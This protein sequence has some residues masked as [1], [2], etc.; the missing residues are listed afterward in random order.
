MNVLYKVFGYFCRIRAVFLEFLSIKHRVLG[1]FCRLRIKNKKRSS[2][3]TSFFFEVAEREGFEPPVPL[4]TVV[5]KTTVIDHS[6]ISPLHWG[7]RGFLIAGAKVRRKN[8]TT[9]FFGNYFAKKMLLIRFL[10]REAQFSM[11]FICILSNNV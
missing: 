3:R 4:G 11:V 8:E 6:T 1:Y 10:S 7:N 2:K 9:K 5:F